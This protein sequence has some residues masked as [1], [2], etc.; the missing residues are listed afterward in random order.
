MA[1]HFAPHPGSIAPRHDGTSPLTFWF[2]NHLPD[3]LLGQASAGLHGH[4]HD[5]LDY[6]VDGCR[7]MCNPSGFSQVF[8]LDDLDEIAREIL[9]REYRPLVK[10]GRICL[11]EVPAFRGP[12]VI[13]LDR[14]GVHDGP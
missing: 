7:V 11:D 4:T 6:E 9:L 3:E 8:V 12:Q 1:T 2:V 14:Q 13:M 10:D 5:R